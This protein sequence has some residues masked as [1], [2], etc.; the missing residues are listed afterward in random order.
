MLDTL[1]V[2]LL[3]SILY[4]TLS[5][6]ATLDSQKHFCIIQPE[7]QAPNR[8]REGVEGLCWV[9]FGYTGCKRRQLLRDSMVE[10]SPPLTVAPDS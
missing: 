2:S 9:L 3:A 8:Q 5:K 1:P 6:I 7:S 4:H 10:A